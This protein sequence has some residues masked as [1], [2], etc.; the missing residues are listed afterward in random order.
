MVAILI[1]ILAFLRLL[2]LVFGCKPGHKP[3]HR[4]IFAFVS[5]VTT[6]WLAAISFAFY[7]SE[8]GRVDSGHIE[9]F[10][11]DIVVANRISL[12]HIKL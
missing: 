7:R 5:I 3:C 6:A 1:L 10:C 9:A 12:H 2:L 4:L 8:M 11:I